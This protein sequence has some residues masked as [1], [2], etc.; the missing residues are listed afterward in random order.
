MV[1]SSGVLAPVDEREILPAP[2]DL[3]PAA[4]ASPRRLTQFR[5]AARAILLYGVT[6]FTVVTDT[7]KVSLERGE[8]SGAYRLTDLRTGADDVRGDAGFGVPWMYRVCEENGLSYTFGFSANPRLKALAQPLLEQAEAV[9]AA[10]IQVAHRV[11]A[12]MALIGSGRMGSF[13]GETVSRRLTGAL[14]G[15]LWIRG[16][17]YAFGTNI[18]LF[19]SAFG[20]LL[21]A[22][23]AG[24]GA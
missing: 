12:L 16:I 2:E 17:P 20:V 1:R 23:V 15:A 10:A 19:T 9:A 13:H 24:C 4:P 18:G 6:L 21:L 8:T 7:H 11:G 5:A 22:S 14:L 3:L